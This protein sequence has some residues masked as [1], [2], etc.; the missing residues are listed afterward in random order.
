M[1][2]P[3]DYMPS[4]G[5]LLPGAD[6]GTIANLEAV[7]GVKLPAEFRSFLEWADGGV[8]PGRRFIVYSAGEGVHPA[9]TILAANR[10]RKTS[11]PFL[12]VARASEE[13][14]GFRIADLTKE[15]CAVFVYL[16]EEDRFA[17]IAPSFP[18]F[19]A[20]AISS[21]QPSGR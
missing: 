11:E 18:E 3:E 13:E 14:F 1:K 9:E 12:F 17:H 2:T 16:H 6:P 20:W 10:N 7:L 19:M 5:D 4:R 21:S 15:P 8:L